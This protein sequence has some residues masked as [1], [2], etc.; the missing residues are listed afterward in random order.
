MSG[1]LMESVTTLLV[2]VVTTAVPILGKKLWDW[3]HEKIQASAASRLAEAA[4]RTAGA[5]YVDMATTAGGLEALEAVRAAAVE[6]GSAKVAKAVE[7]GSATLATALQGA[8][9]T[10]RG[11]PADVENV[12]KGE[13]GKILA[14]RPLT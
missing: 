13:L 4:K 1:T 14:Q 7:A 2:A 11:T 3:L 9:T 6:A 10:L 12:V 8:V 5:I